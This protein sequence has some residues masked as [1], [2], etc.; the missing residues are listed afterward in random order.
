MSKS[1]KK[2]KKKINVI[3]V[4]I[5]LLVLALIA[6]AGY[7][8]YSEIT[9]NSGA[10]KSN[11]I[12]TFECEAA[13]RS[14]VKYLK[15][16][17]AVYLSSDGTLLG[18]LYDPEN[19]GKTG[20]VY[21][22]DEGTE[23]ETQLKSELDKNITLIGTLK[24]STDA[25]KANNGSYYVLNGRN[26]TVGGSFDVYTDKAVLKITVKNIESAG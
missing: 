18:Y 21:E 10:K 25:L 17:D 1:V 19:D 7:R 9:E 15:P 12:L 4:M 6:T 26:I 20:A 14:E 5:I 3:D 11:N 23:I 16:G 2:N 24:L 22:A 8:I 13:Y